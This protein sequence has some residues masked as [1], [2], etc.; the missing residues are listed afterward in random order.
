[1]NWLDIKH[2]VRYFHVRWRCYIC[3]KRVFPKKNTKFY[4][5]GLICS[6]CKKCKV[7]DWDI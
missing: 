7:G 6:L 4:N 1:M 3:D 5:D 2:N